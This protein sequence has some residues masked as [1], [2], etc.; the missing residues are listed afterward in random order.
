MSRSIPSFEVIQI[1]DTREE[2]RRA[3]TRDKYVKRFLK[4]KKEFESDG[5]SLREISNVA[6]KEVL[7]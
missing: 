6:K 3:K 2:E 7:K 4:L 5:F 1:E